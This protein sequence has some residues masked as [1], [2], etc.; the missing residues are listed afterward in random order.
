MH[1]APLLEFR[2]DY[3]DGAI[4]QM[5][6]WKIKAPLAGSAHHYK[7]RL[8]YGYPGRRLVCYDNE[9]GKGDH[10]HIG[11]REES[12]NFVS[13]DQLLNDFLEDVAA[14]RSR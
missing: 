8:F 13:I 6:V 4:A 12:Y 3:D 1:A 9:Q 2:Q 11:D 7:Y 5:V 14:R 10:R